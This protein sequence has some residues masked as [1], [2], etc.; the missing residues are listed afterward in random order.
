MRRSREEDLYPLFVRYL[1]SNLPKCRVYVHG[2]KYQDI[3]GI[4]RNA[5]LAPGVADLV[6]FVDGRWLEVEVKVGK[7]VQSKTQTDHQKIV[8]ECG[9]IYVVAQTPEQAEFLIRARLDELSPF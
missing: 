9:G 3:R 2:K 8:E 1:Q 5:H 6:G 7:N 4:W